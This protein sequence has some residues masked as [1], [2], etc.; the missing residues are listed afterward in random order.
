[1]SDDSD[2]QSSGLLICGDG[3]MS[4]MEQVSLEENKVIHRK[5]IEEMENKKNV[6]M[7]YEIFQ[8][9]YI[10]HEGYIGKEGAERVYP[11]T[12][13]MLKQSVIKGI[14]GFPDRRLRIN[15]QVA[16]NDRVVTYWTGNGTHSGT[17][18]GIGATGKEVRW[19]GIYI[20]RISNGRIVEHW[21]Y[22]DA[23]SVLMQIGA[24]FG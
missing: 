17:W 24:K 22:F 16:E 14:G 15:F 19:D 8:N 23:F 4:R 9:G 13:E 5:L 20:S 6:D 12:L 2:L 11:V 21:V 1:L 7:I 18:L 3:E 10:V